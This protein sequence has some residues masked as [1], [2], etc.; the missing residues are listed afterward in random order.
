MNEQTAIQALTTLYNDF[1]SYFDEGRIIVTGSFYY[2][3]IDPSYTLYYHDIDIVIDERPEYDYIL[4]EI[5][6]HYTN[7]DPNFAGFIERYDNTLIGCVGIL[8][9]IIDNSTQ[10]YV[11]VDMF[12]ND[13]SN[14]LPA[15]EIIPGV[16]TQRLPDSKFVELFQD[17]TAKDPSSGKYQTALNFFQNRVNNS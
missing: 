14:N 5:Y 12:R 10:E 8:N 16:F 17:L 11:N 1:Q 4:H 2:S 15:V 6:D 3:Y 7:I 13:F 9:Y